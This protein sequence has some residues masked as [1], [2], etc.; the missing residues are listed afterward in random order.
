MAPAV[1]A[2]LL[3][4]L[5]AAGSMLGPVT[6]SSSSSS[7]SPLPATERGAVFDAAVAQLATPAFDLY[8]LAQSWQPEF[9]AGKPLPG[10][11]APRPFWRSHFTLHGLWPER[12]R[13][14]PPSFCAGEAF[15]ER[16]VE[17][18][19]GLDTLVEFWPNVKAPE[20]SDDYAGFWKHEWTRHG[21]CSGLAQVD[22]FAHA[23]ALVRN[24]SLA[25]TPELIQK[26]VGGS[27]S[28]TSLRAAFA[29][30][31]DYDESAGASVAAALKCVHGDALSQVFTCWEKNTANE[32]VT[33]RACPDHIIREDT[34]FKT[35]VRI[36][37][38]PN[39]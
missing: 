30:P 12:E 5:T 21:T 37:A 38:F 11:A 7:P 16:R 26:N 13:G 14:S 39:A 36:P 25:P 33:R 2:A 10:C 27:V 22:F 8:V 6:C 23:V 4:L 31:G 9:C 29:L 18:A 34:C 1:A 20:G 32:P 19:L 35:T 15:D 17:Q 3:L 24:D 28:A